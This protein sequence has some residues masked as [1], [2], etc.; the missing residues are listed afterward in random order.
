MLKDIGMAMRWKYL[1]N[2][3]FNHF[4]QFFT[5]IAARNQYFFK[6]FYDIFI[7]GFA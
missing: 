7:A 1:L 3:R 2:G 4:E 5:A 6:T